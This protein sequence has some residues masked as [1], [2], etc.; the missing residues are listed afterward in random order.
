MESGL[1]LHVA[2]DASCYSLSSTPP[3][4]AF[5]CFFSAIYGSSV[6]FFLLY[7]CYNI[8]LCFTVSVSLSLCLSSSL[9]LSVPL[10][11]DRLLLVVFS[12]FLFLFF[13]ICASHCCFLCSF[14]PHFSFITT[15]ITSLTTLASFLCLPPL[16][17]LPTPS[18]SPPHPSASFSG[19]R[20]SDAAQSAPR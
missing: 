2:H 16:I 6:C 9:S 10:L 15:A 18:P 5:C 12:Q 3:H 14:S 11:R 1:C 20:M 7:Y 8:L 17:Y 4:A 13:C 19:L